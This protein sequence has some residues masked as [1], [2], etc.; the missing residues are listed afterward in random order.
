MYS[1]VK[2][3]AVVVCWKERP[4]PTREK[5]LWFD[6]TSPFQYIVFQNS[7]I[8]IAEGCRSAGVMSCVDLVREGSE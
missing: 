7:R 3:L 2:K 6:L 5:P 8:V 1:V 4:E